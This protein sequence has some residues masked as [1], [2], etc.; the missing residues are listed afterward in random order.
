MGSEQNEHSIALAA[1]VNRGVRLVVDNQGNRRWYNANNKLHRE[2][3]LPAV[4]LIDGTK[5]WRRDGLL[6]RENDQPDLIRD[7]GARFWHS[8]GKRDWGD[9]G[10][11]NYIHRKGGRPSIEWSSTNHEW[12]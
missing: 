4:E 11:V 1:E 7:D 6:Y 2:G 3:D 10:L 9:M 12:I 5:E 8:I